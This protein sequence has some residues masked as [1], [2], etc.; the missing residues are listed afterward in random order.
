MEVYDVGRADYELTNWWYRMATEESL[1]RGLDVATQQ[2]LVDLLVSWAN[3]LPRGSGSDIGSEHFGCQRSFKGE[4]LGQMS[5]ERVADD[6]VRGIIFMMADDMGMGDV[7][8]FDTLLFAGDGQYSSRTPNIDRMARRGA[9]LANFY[10]G[11]NV[12][13][14]T[15]ASVLTGRPPSHADVRFHSH[16]GRNPGQNRANGAPLYLGWGRAEEIREQNIASFFKGQ[17]YA[18]GHFGKWHV[19]VDTPAPRPEW[20]G[21]DHALCYSCTRRDYNLRPQLWPRLDEKVTSDA[22]EWLDTQAA[23]R[24][25][26]FANV[27]F[28]QPHSPLDF[29]PEESSTQL[30]DLGY[31]SQLNPFP[32]KT[33][34]DV[35]N[36]WTPGVERALPRQIYRAAVADMDRQVGRFMDW[37]D[38]LPAYYSGRVLLVFTADNGPEAQ[39]GYFA[40]VGN[41]GPYRG[42]KRTVYEGGIHMP[43]VMMLTGSIPAGR[44][45]NIPG[46]TIDLVRT[47]AG[48]AQVGPVP[49]RVRGTDLSCFLT[50][51]R[52][53]AGCPS[54]DGEAP[55][56]DGWNMRP[57]IIWEYR[58]WA[59]FQDCLQVSPRFAIRRGRFKL[60]MEP[61]NWK[62]RLPR[63]SDGY[64]RLELYDLGD[65]PA[66]SHDLLLTQKG[67]GPMEDVRDQLLAEL[68]EYLLSDEYDT[69]LWPDNASPVTTNFLVSHRS[70]QG[71]EPR[72]WIVGEEC[73]WVKAINAAG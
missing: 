6:P 64:A 37:A 40:G 30:A 55:N 38:A 29:E 27:W 17:G 67:N 4:E 41:T 72:T 68:Y 60:L 26:F 16:L 59:R 36:E 13:S 70:L 51:P 62:R 7:G 58:Y 53:A 63:P 1:P 3:T 11:G 46:S 15:R 61:W 45:V 57:A 35:V 54:L 19:G 5:R 66:E 39:D 20:Y 44:V 9:A 2:S 47:F 43:G 21:F 28:H 32:N 24:K 52:G 42:K 73:P 31:P 33:R 14:P 8:F 49:S 22:L 65:D 12:C 10:S 69:S 23:A 48:L 25:K 56:P 50:H 71:G 34:A 18:T